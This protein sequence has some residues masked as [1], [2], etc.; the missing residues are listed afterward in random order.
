[1]KPFDNYIFLDREPTKFEPSGHIQR[2]ERR[3]VELNG[4]VLRSNKA[5]VDVKVLDLSYDGCSIATL[6]PLL[7]GEKV[8]L[9]VLGRG[10]VATTVLW[11]KGRRAG[12]LFETGRISKTNWPR[13][14]ERIEIKAE[15]S[16]RRQGRRYRVSTLDVTRFGCRCE[17]VE[18]PAVY[19]RLWIKFDRLDAIEATV[20]WIEGS[21]LGLMYLHPIH[22]AVFEMLLARLD[23]QVGRALE[24]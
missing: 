19:E 8:K 16:L 11:Y 1:M 23:P 15:A 18:R 12:L 13:K 2:D 14:A 17:F 9:S 24:G 21:S 20:C 10:A 22:P 4:Y 6:V 5:I 7:P 3:S